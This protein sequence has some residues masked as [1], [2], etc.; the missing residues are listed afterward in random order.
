[1]AR[2]NGQL[3]AVAEKIRAD[4]KSMAVDMWNAHLRNP[5]N[6]AKDIATAQAAIVG[7]FPVPNTRED[8]V[9][10]LAVASGEATRPINRMMLAPVLDGSD[11]IVGAWKAKAQQALVKAKVM[12]PGDPSIAHAESVLRG[13]SS[14][15]RAR[16]AKN[17]F[18]WVGIVAACLFVVPLLSLGGGEMSDSTRELNEERCKGV[19]SS[20]DDQCRYRACRK[21]CV[22]SDGELRPGY[23]WACKKAEGFGN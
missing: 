23:E 15:E 19:V 22:K 18:L 6:I 4:R 13:V 20:C 10:F 11:V 9:E 5:V 8:L 21:L 16:I 3:T 14:A 12:M 2:L 17:P 7:S 1:M